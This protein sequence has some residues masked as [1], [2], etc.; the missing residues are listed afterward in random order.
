VL[1]ERSGT[2]RGD[3]LKFV[4]AGLLRAG[5]SRL[6]PNGI[7]LWTGVYPGDHARTGAVSEEWQGTGL[8]LAGTL[9]REGR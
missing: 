1:A 5:A 3:E 7:A 2:G 9:T 8:Q 4:R 6:H